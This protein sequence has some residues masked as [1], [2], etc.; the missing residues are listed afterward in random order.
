MG[1]TLY[2]IPHSFIWYSSAS[3]K[4]G[5]QPTPLSTDTILSLGQRSRK[6]DTMMLARTRP[7]PMKSN[8]EL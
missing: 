6:R 2:L 8:A 5:I 1:G 3:R 7:L 4:K